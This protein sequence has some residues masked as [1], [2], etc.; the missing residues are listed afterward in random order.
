MVCPLRLSR[1][2]AI[3]INERSDV[4]KGCIEMKPV[5]FPDLRRSHLAGLILPA[6]LI[7]DNQFF[8]CGTADV[9]DAD[10]VKT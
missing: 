7:V 4:E 9:P 8:N 2:A 5:V 3:K 10:K 6:Y 1:Y